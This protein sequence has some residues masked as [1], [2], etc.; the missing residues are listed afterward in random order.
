MKIGM[1]ER[2]EGEKDIKEDKRRKGGKREK[3]GCKNEN[4]RGK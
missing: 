4:I 2:K 3:R 1:E